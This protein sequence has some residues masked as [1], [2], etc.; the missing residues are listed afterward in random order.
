MAAQV[1]LGDSNISNLGGKEEH[2]ARL[3]A[4]STEEDWQGA[5]TTAGV[6]IWRIENLRKE[7]GTPNFGV[8]PWPKE[9]YGNFYLGDS[10]IILHTKADPGTGKL[11]WDAYFW[12]GPESSQDEYT[13]AAYK[14]VELDDYLG[15]NPVIHKIGQ[16]TE[17]DAFFSAF[18]G[19]V[20]Y[21]TGGIASGFRTVAPETFQPRLFQVRKI[22]RKTR[23]FQVP[24]HRDSLNHGDAFVLDAGAIVYTWS[25]D[26]ASPFEKAKAAKVAHNIV[27]SRDG[28]ASKQN[29]EGDEFWALLGGEGEISPETNRD[30]PEADGQHA[31][32]V[33][34]ITDA[35]SV[36]RMMEKPATRESLT[37]ADAYCIDAGNEI[38]VWVGSSATKREGQ[39]A[40][41]KAHD[42]IKS[43]DK[44]MSTKVTRV[45]E[46][47]ESSSGMWKSSGL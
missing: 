34:Q 16:G 19:Q 20:Q 37:S 33:F 7:D 14:V 45:R 30:P 39:Q 32:K 10:F 11:S 12:V 8:N 44:P 47:Q 22:N 35:D 1:A 38:F 27:Q 43:F 42:L 36:V 31:T 28:H 25:G 40:F 2:D 21:C 13:V 24:L 26:D 46:G 41:I 23:S 5:G 9:E 4:A 3:A 6:Q 18:G 17:P 29:G 15:G